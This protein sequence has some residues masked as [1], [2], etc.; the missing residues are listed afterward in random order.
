MKTD[1]GGY[2]LTHLEFVVS[3]RQRADQPSLA[4]VYRGA[5][6]VHSPRTELVSG[7]FPEEALKGVSPETPAS[8][9]E[10]VTGK[11]SRY[12]AGRDGQLPCL[13]LVPPG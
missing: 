13:V 5:S 2:G 8:P 12:R 10:V 11:W 9:T 6:P 4:T 3:V 1:K 7:N